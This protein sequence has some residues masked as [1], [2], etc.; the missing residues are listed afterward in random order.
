MRASAGAIGFGGQAGTGLT[1]RVNDAFAE[2][3]K[4]FRSQADAISHADLSRRALPAGWHGHRHVGRLS[5]DHHGDG[6]PVLRT[7][8]QGRR[9]GGRGVHAR[10]DR[11]GCRSHRLVAHHHREQRRA[12]GP[13]AEHEAEGHAGRSR[14][15][16]HAGHGRRRA[17][18]AAGTDVP[19]ERGARRLCRRRR[20]GRAAGR[21]NPGRR[22]RRHAADA[23]PGH[24]SAGHLYL[25]SAAQPARSPVAA[26]HRPDDRH[27]GHQERRQRVVR[28][29]HGVLRSA[30]PRRPDGGP[31]VGPAWDEA[32]SSWDRATST[33][34]CG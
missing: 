19:A 22:L 23:G 7:S 28:A 8:G 18:D 32:T 30:W 12:P 14:A 9:A 2:V 13:R 6:A 5:R 17:A 31:R 3:V 1:L 20:P 11:A 15:F 10:I 16:R 21:R 33:P 24:G 26:R 29:R 34:R 27:R 4:G 25:R